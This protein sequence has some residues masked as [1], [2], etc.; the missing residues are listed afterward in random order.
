MLSHIFIVF[1]K[2][3]LFLIKLFAFLRLFYMFYTFW[4]K[5]QMLFNFFVKPIIFMLLL[6]HAKM[7]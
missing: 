2:D 1:Q 7:Q 5:T 3:L 6:I 4:Y